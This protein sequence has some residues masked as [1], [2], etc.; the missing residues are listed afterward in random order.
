M[1]ETYKQKVLN[2][3]NIN[4][5]EALSLS[6]EPDK[7]T[8]YKA[9]NEIRNHFCGKDF[10]LCSITN[11]KSGKCSQNCKWC[12]QSSNNDTNIEEYELVDRDFA[13]KKAIENSKQGVSRHSLVTSG[14]RVND[15]TLSSL[16]SIYRE[17]RKNSNI[18]LCASMGLIN[19]HQ[20]LRL[21]NEAKIEYY[22]CNLETAPSYFSHLVSSHSID[23]KI[24]TI[25]SAQEAGL[26]VCS[27]GIIGMG[28]TMEHRI[29]LALTLRNLGILSIPINILDPIQGT[30]LENAKLLN[31]T[32]ILTTIALFRF[33]NPQA[34]IRFAGGRLRIKAIQE[35]ALRAGIN[36][37][38]TGNFLTSKGAKIRDD[39]K[40]F[41]NAGF[42]LSYGYK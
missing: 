25:K 4:Y 37:A 26:K 8:L 2:G 15:K 28:E 16:I 9:A 39:I 19:K 29:E 42:K 41:T 20:M 18:G 11:A 22:H 1:V 10:E 27:G 21:K 35:K 34:N 12:A 36:A 3:Y 17:I 14:K 7:E 33:I 24:S 5:K 31:E 38:I 40:D 13:V 30:P 32:E 6:N 23:E